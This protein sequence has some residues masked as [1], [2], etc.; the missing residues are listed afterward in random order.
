MLASAN[1]QRVFPHRTPVRVRE[2]RAVRA[3]GR[4]SPICAGSSVISGVVA[5]VGGDTWA[6]IVDGAPAD[7][8]VIVDF[9]TDWCGPCKV[10]YPKYEALATET[11]NTTFLR[12]NCNADNKEKAKEVGIKVAPT[13]MF[14][15][16]GEKLGEVR[17]AKWDD[18]LAELAKNS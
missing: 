5:D 6:E 15:K 9:Y 11:P 10:L 1:R 3:A 8:L 16:N 17:G 4:T 13:F 12:F 14:Y 2:T 7:R 18:V